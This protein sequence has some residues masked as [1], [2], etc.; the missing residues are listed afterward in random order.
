[1][2]IIG[3]VNQ[4]GSYS[5]S[6]YPDLKSLIEFGAKGIKPRTNTD[7][8]DIFRTDLEWKQIF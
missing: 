7:K 1:M 2:T 3:S 6:T 8:V 5:K 4:P